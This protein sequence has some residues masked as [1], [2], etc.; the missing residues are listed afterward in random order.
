MEMGL[1]R[2][3]VALA[4]ALLLHL[5]GVRLLPHF[6]DAADVFLVVV[7]WFSLSGRPASAQLSGMGAGLVHDALSGSPFG[8]HGMANTVVGYAVARTAQKLLF[9]QRGTRTLAFLLAAAVQQAAVVALM[10]FLLPNSQLPQLRWILVKLAV[11]P[12]LGLALV[13]GEARARRWWAARRG[14]R[15]SRLRLG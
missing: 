4:G 14:R 11:T 9:Q 10:V 12:A 6:A 7:V 13:G 2:Y 8:L 1:L 5:I 3:L 15:G